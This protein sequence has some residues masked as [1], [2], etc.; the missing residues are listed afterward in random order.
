MTV[1]EGMKMD[2]AERRLVGL[3]KATGEWFGTL[4]SQFFTFLVFLWSSIF[5]ITSAGVDTRG[6]RPCLGTNRH[7]CSRSLTPDNQKRLFAWCNVEAT[8]WRFN[9]FATCFES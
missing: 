4:Q 9:T 6:Q 5:F 3:C 7:P 1:R 8:M 2:C